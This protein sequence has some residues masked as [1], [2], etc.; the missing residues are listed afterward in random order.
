MFFALIAS[1]MSTGSIVPRPPLGPPPDYLPPLETRVTAASGLSK[2]TKPGSVSS[3]WS[4]PVTSHNPARHTAKSRARAVFLEGE[5]AKF[6]EMFPP[7]GKDAPASASV[8]EKPVDHL[9]EL[10][11][12]IFTLLCALKYMYCSVASFSKYCA[13]VILDSLP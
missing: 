5:R 11:S 8:G 3:A 7:L 9:K 12:S 10:V 13:H 6:D 2:R 1:E 4:R